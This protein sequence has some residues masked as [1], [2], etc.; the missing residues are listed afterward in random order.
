LGIIVFQLWL[1]S[2]RPK[3]KKDSKA[4]QFWRA[5]TPCIQFWRDKHGLADAEDNSAARSGHE[6]TM[7]R[8]LSESR[9]QQQQQH[10]RYQQHQQQEE[11]PAA[12]ADGIVNLKSRIGNFEV[13][14]VK[15]FVEGITPS[16]QF[17][18]DKHGLADAEDNSAA[19]SGLGESREQQQPQH[20]RYQQQQEEPPAAPEDGT[21]NLKSRIGNFKISKV[22]RLVEGIGEHLGAEVE[23]DWTTVQNVR[24]D[25]VAS[26]AINSNSET[27]W[28]RQVNAEQQTFLEAARILGEV[29]HSATHRK[30]PHFHV[31]DRQL[32][33]MEAHFREFSEDV[34]IYP[35]RASRNAPM[36]D[37]ME[38]PFM[39]LAKDG[40]RLKALLPVSQGFVKQ[41]VADSGGK[42]SGMDL[43]ARTSEDEALLGVTAG[44][45]R[46]ELE[47]AF[48]HRAREMHAHGQC[49]KQDEFYAL[50]NAYE[51]GLARL[52]DSNFRNAY[53]GGGD[54]LAHYL[55][56]G[57]DPSESRY[58]EAVSGLLDALR[59]E[60]LLMRISVL[61]VFG[62]EERGGTG[63]GQ[64]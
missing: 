37:L 28:D 56:V 11:P 49:T 64:G 21:V 8:Q 32:K 34:L 13:S 3:K 19:R 50:N 52:V 9:E 7:S 31:V 33:D 60:R 62:E 35:W 14:K 39:Q 12:T 4:A 55:L 38:L 36:S 41:T 51:R 16:M 58:G 44:A 10:Q 15:R 27:E 26:A 30:L 47:S 24:D 20:Q 42:H 61:Q 43:E 59:R 1:A 23:F 46:Q 48:R 25:H 17:W 29:R 40:N 18:R 53:S 5:C 22:K 2:S 6:T 54:I 45:N 57:T 63:L